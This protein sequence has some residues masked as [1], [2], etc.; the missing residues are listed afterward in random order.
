MTQA[1]RNRQPVMLDFYADWC[2][3]CKVM[4]RNVFSAA[5]VIDALAPYTLLQIDM[6]D[7]TTAQQALLDELGLFGPPAIL[8]F[9]R[10]GEELPGAR[11]LG[12]MD[13]DEFLRHLSS[14]DV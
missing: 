7:N 4:E 12:E 10:D 5:D 9:G 3:S 14:L 1:R 8:F 6:T 13:R 11:V 2:I